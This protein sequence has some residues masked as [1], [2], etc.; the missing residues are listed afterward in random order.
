MSVP[1][2]TIGAQTTQSPSTAA[3]DSFM[4]QFKQGAARAFSPG[5]IASFVN[6]NPKALQV[7]GALGGA[8]LS[9]LG[10]MSFINVFKLLSNPLGYT[11]NIYYLIFGL[12]ILFTSLAG[13]HWLSHRVYS[14]FNFLSNARGRALFFVFIA[15]LLISQIMDG[16]FSWLYLVVGVYLLL[17]GVASGV[18]A[19]QMS[20]E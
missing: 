10:V 1:R 17:L 18:V 11:L 13:D 16:Q 15:S 9:V 12:T 3:S 7:L 2:S 6:S 4:T 20:R 19:W 5:D 8:G 14:E